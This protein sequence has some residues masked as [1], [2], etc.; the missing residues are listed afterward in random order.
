MSLVDRPG[1]RKTRA[2]ELP[3][4]R[5]AL[6]WQ[7]NDQVARHVLDGA[8]VMSE[9]APRDEASGRVYYGTT[10][11]R[12]FTRSAAGSIPD[13]RIDEAL[14]WTRA[15]PHLRLRVLRLAHR[16]ATLRAGGALERVEAELS[17][18]R[19]GDALQIDVEVEARL[20][21]MTQERRLA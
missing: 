2:A 21:S 4:K 17:F 3:R 7:S 18:S 12:L 1:L 20:S 8:D 13:D 14:R 5:T 10:S 19:V 9:G 6:L 15:D 16:E 11:I